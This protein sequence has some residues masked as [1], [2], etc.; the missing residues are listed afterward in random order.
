M[1][2]D[3]QEDPVGQVAA[4][5]QAGGSVRFDWIMI[6][7]C[8]W[9]LSGVYIDGWAHNH[10]NIIDTFFTP[11]HAALY[12]GFLSIVIFLA[13]TLAR[14]IRKGYRWWAAVPPGYG[15]AL[16]GIVVFG[17]G[18]VGDFFWH[19]LFGFDVE[20][21]TLLSPT[22]LM[23]AAGGLLIVSAP[24]RS[25]WLRPRDGAKTRW[26]SQLP[27][28]LSLTFVLGALAFMTSF[29]HPFVQT[30]A[31]SGFH[32][33]G[34]SPFYIYLNDLVE[35]WG[36]LSILLRSSLLIGTMLLLIWRQQVPPG[37]F[38]IMMGLSFSMSSVLLGNYI[39]IPVAILGGMAADGFYWLFK[40]SPE[41][42]GALR[43]FVF[44]VPV[45]L[46]LLYFLDLRLFRSM[47]WPLTIWTGSIFMSGIAGL[48][49]SY[50]LVPP[51]RG[52]AK[53]APSFLTSFQ[54]TR[55]RVL[56]GL[57]GLGMAA[58]GLSV[59]GDLLLHRPGAPFTGGFTNVT[60][61]P[62]NGFPAPN[63][64]QA[65]VNV[66]D[67]LYQAGSAVNGAAWS[68]DGKFIAAAYA[69]GT[70][71]IWAANA[72][73]GAALYTYHKH[74]G[75]ATS[76]A[77]S[78]DG[79]L[80]ASAGEDGTVQ[81]WHV[82]SGASFL[83]YRGHTGRVLAVAWSSTGNQIASA[84]EDKT[85]QLWDAVTGANML[86]YRKHSEAVGTLAWSP[87]SRRIVSASMKGKAFV[88]DTSA[89]AAIAAFQVDFPQDNAIDVAWSPDGK[90]I[91]TAR[92][93]L[94]IWNASTGGL[95]NF[96]QDGNSD[97]V[98]VA[99]SPDGKRLITGHV[100]G[101]LSILSAFP[102]HDATTPVVVGE[103][104]MKFGGDALLSGGG[105]EGTSL[106]LFQICQGHSGMVN[107]VGWAPGSRYAVSAGDD[108]TVQIWDTYVGNI[109]IAYQHN[110]TS[111]DWSPD[112]KRIASVVGNNGIEIWD[113]ATAT[114]TLMYTKHPSSSTI[115]CLSWSPDSQ[116]M[117]SAGDDGIVLIWDTQTAITRFAVKLAQSMVDVTWLSD[118]KHVAL[119]DGKGV[120]QIW[121]ATTGQVLKKFVIQSAGVTAV[122]WSPDEKR[123]AVVDPY[124]RVHILGTLKQS[125]LSP[126]LPGLSGVTSLAWSPDGRQLASV[127]G[128]VVQVWDATTGHVT[129][130]YQEAQFSG[131]QL[132][133][134]SDG[135]RLAFTTDQGVQVWNVPDGKLLLTYLGAVRNSVSIFMASWSPD[136]KRI[137]S[138]CTDGS[139]QI[140]LA[141]A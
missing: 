42:V 61:E 34:S 77:W 137:A 55:R 20:L 118:G 5:K 56:V 83:T 111:A 8:S 81:V 139:V 22:H 105:P 62:Y 17:I 67:W 78:P 4:Y 98:R 133:W 60:M 41:H 89:G 66:P 126:P 36:V 110:F 24:L 6:L 49:L 128:G 23:L 35:S 57:A 27:L 7:L 122:A 33:N 69:D 76:L 79:K 104:A 54:V 39:L 37:T 140:W 125:P 45:S 90:Y 121:D 58:G 75:A 91:A 31:T 70:I 84:G 13:I 3:L 130:S 21:A 18:G 97:T 10:F 63:S 74:S 102:S 131:A 114:A 72:R 1:S 38:T 86:T 115:A 94:S 135:K 15:L 103:D 129:F 95:L 11:W 136:G 40:P 9:L 109:Q 32:A 47:W 50:V 96:Y 71:Q 19:T 64:P 113:A 138:T 29:A 26:L 85:V 106:P 65:I 16:L 46:F 132:V 92:S 119:V 117:I 112:G 88:W 30:P 25:A 51:L 101:L 123:I 43:L 100:N 99:W 127:D 52:G 44:V 93:S 134:A 87:D 124:N 107:A 68:P 28:I 80:I 120:M 14:N 108:A 82:A 59:A 12:S 2:A 53:P 141:P 48:L 116:Q 73:A